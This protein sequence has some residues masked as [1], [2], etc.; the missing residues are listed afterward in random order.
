MINDV[1]ESSDDYEDFS[2]NAND[3]IRDWHVD[4]TKTYSK[5]EVDEENQILKVVV[6]ASKY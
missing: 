1:G 2:D 6:L 4:H 5:Q 3:G